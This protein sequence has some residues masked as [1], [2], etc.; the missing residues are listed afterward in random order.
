MVVLA[1]LFHDG[2]AAFV[3]RFLLAASSLRGRAPAGAAER[4]RLSAHKNV[5]PAP[6]AVTSHYACCYASTHGTHP[7]TFKIHARAGYSS[8]RARFL[9]ALPAGFTELPFQLPTALPCA[10]RICRRAK[11]HIYAIFGQREPLENI[12]FKRIVKEMGC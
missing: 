7:F 10:C 5:T 11:H 1:D 3:K 4:A 8:A 12:T 6:L 2:S 9:T